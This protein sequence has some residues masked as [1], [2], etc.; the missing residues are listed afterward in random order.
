M[1]I[2]EKVFTQALHK[3]VVMSSKKQISS[4]NHFKNM[5]KKALLT[6]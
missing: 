6:L 4:Y 3:K 1:I 2:L 5:D